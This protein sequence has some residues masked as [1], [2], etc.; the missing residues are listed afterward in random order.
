MILHGVCS[1]G[2]VGSLSLGIKWWVFKP[3]GTAII[4]ASISGFLFRPVSGG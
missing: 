2:V 1:R 4:S 3:L